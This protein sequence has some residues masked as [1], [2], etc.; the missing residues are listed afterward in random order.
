MRENRKLG[1]VDEVAALSG[2]HRRDGILVVVHCRR[3][4]DGR[5]SGDLARLE[6]LFDGHG[7]RAAFDIPA[8]DEELA[9]EL[10]D[11]AL[12]AFTATVRLRDGSFTAGH[13][14]LK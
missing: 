2:V 3:I 8:R 12:Q 5:G 9:V 7:H 10:I 14:S 4:R 1:P 13:A 11:D 6:V